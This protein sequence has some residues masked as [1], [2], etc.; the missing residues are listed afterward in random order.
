MDSSS[1]TLQGKKVWRDSNGSSALRYPIFC[2]HLLSA[3]ILTESEA[4]PFKEKNIALVTIVYLPLVEIS[5]QC[6]KK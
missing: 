5:E 6:C 3:F 4:W 1:P 2:W